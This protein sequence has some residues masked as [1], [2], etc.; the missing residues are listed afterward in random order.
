MATDNGASRRKLKVIFR[1][2]ITLILQDIAFFAPWPMRT[3][4]HRARGVKIGN[5]V[6]LG[7]LVVLD[8]AYPE[9]II[10]E[11]HVQVSAGA[12]ILAHD[13]SFNNVF[14]GRLPTYIGSVVIKQHAYIGSG[15]LILPGV[16][17]GERA[18]VGAGAIVTSDVPPR[19]VVV[20][21][22][23]KVVGTID[24]KAEKFLSRQGLFIW[25]YYERPKR[26][27]E[28]EKDRIREQ[29]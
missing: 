12:K 13:S 28:S 23:A 10:V 29:L 18:I 17:V 21:G 9:Y 26:L 7:S 19:A 16:T 25:K 11:D 6:F 1:R 8:D 24:E 3:Y 4:L 2:L 5:N 14:E 22:P 15:A 20:G 27:T